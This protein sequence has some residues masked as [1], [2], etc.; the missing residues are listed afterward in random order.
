MLA[1]SEIL[2]II[3]KVRNTP[4]AK[5]Y[6]SG[7]IPFF[8]KESETDSFRERQT[9]VSLNLSAGRVPPSHT[10]CRSNCAALKQKLQDLN[11]F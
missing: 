2:E 3:R 9:K 7:L 4:E 6:L 8:W 1:V 10:S 5:L 11:P